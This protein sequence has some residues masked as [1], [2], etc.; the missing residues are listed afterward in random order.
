MSADSTAPVGRGRLPQSDGLIALFVDRPVLTLMVALTICSLGVLSFSKLPLRLAPQE[1]ADA[2]V[3]LWVPISQDMT[4]Q[5]VQEQILEPLESQLSTIPGVSELRSRCDSDSAF[6]SIGLDA[7]T[8]LILAAAEVRDRA[9]RAKL[10]WPRGIDRYFTWREDASSAPLAFFQIL[11]PERNP[12][13]DDKIERLV[14]PSLER[15]DGVGR[16]DMFGL[17]PESLR[18]WFDREKLVEYR[19]DYGQLIQQLSRDNFARPIGEVDDGNSRFMARVDA[20]F[21]SQEEIENYPIR[22]GLRIKDIARVERVVSVR[23]SLARFDGKYTY[24]GVLRPAA[25][26]N[27]VDASRAVKVEMDAMRART[28]LAG[29]DFRVLFDQGAMIEGSLDTLLSTSIQ[30]ALLALVAL[31][32]FLRNVRATIAI[33]LAIPLA[34]LCSGIYLYFFGRTLNLLTM[35]GMT[36]AVGMVVDNS[37]VILENIRRLRESG[38]RMRDAAIQGTRELVLAIS[39][40][41]STTVVVILPLVFMSSDTNLRAAFGAIGITLSVALIGS[42]F[43]ALLLLPS[44]MRHLGAGV[45]AV[46][47]AGRRRLSPWSPMSWL[48]GINRAALRFSLRHRIWASIGCVLLCGSS[49]FAMKGLDFDERGGGPGRRGDVSIYLEIPRGMSLR[50][51]ADEIETY[52]A[53]IKDNAA[54]WNIEHTAV[55]FDRDSARF[56]LML[57]AEFDGEARDELTKVIRAAWPRRPGIR[58]TLRDRSGGGGMGGGGGMQDSK[59]SKN[60]VLRLWGADSEFLTARALDLAEKLDDHEQVESVEV[61]RVSGNQEVVV[62]LD[63]QRLSDFG[64]PSDRL[65]R[66]MSSGLRGIELTRFEDGERD[67]RLI[68]QFDAERNPSLVDL[69]ETR[70]WK[71]N[72][73]FQRIGDLSQISFV[74]SLERINRLDR[75]TTIQLEG[76]RADGVTS[77]AFSDTLRRLMLEN[78]LP[79]GYTWSEAS[80][81]NEIAEQLEELQSAGLLSIALVFMLMGVLFESVI[82]PSSILVT[83]FFAGAGAFWSLRLFYGSIDIMAGI[84]IVLLGGIVV[85][86]GIVLLDCIERLR[87][88]GRSRNGAILRGVRIR[89]RP[90]V[91]TATTTI[92]GLLP[93]ALFGE[94]TGDGISYVSMSIAVAGGLALCTVCTAF[95]VPLAYTFMDDLSRW[96]RG[97]FQRVLPARSPQDAGVPARVAVPE[98]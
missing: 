96:M 98:S 68:A 18:I 80:Y 64:V 13:W 25:G 54:Q 87:G 44:G 4:P 88:E 46:L 29:I 48:T 15:I 2:Q 22:T 66:T 3:N 7:D 21:R 57:D 92:V 17:T 16:V 6:C 84:G 63:R 28:D 10:E 59:N 62:A 37:V 70:V 74:R 90:I 12:D 35:A 41:T 34:L 89:L 60:F 50:E 27:P 42:L 67:V 72:G 75:K 53:F 94:S 32:L 77:I 40:A 8:D 81:S 52:E 47:Q 5:E 65:N 30:G 76:R 91:M 39:M 1:M 86:N 26:T 56:D 71:E 43:V 51:V 23:D 36:L 82:L 20:K 55:R 95:A 11:T 24:T 31:F 14:Q 33:A 19:I 58:L 49:Y 38:M 69:K 9:Q 45:G 78:P 85:N 83:L 97:V 73:A 61:D 93:M 79:R